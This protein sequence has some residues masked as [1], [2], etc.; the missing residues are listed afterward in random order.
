MKNIKQLAKLVGA[1]TVAV[2]LALGARAGVQL[3]PLQTTNFISSAVALINS[4]P[5]NSLQT[6]GIG[7]R[8]GTSVNVA[9]TR[10]FG[11]DVQG[12]LLNTNAT[13]STIYLQFVPSMV[14]GGS[15]LTGSK[16][17]VV[18]GTNVLTFGNTVITQNDFADTNQ[19]FQINVP[20]PGL[21][22]NWFHWMTNISQ[23]TWPAGT[24]ASWVGLF[25]ISNNFTAGS[26]ITN[27]NI[28]ISTKLV[29]AP[30]IGN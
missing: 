7:Q 10:D 27:V 17:Q 4:F 5:T 30:L 20:V 1:G 2:G 25:G 19:L 23:V 21:T 26:Y 28:G 24:C 3:K 15:G 14:N 8:T 13:A 22:T 29:P 18:L 11:V 9:D 6:N 16:P 12:F